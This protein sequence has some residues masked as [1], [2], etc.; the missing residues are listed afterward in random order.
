MTEYTISFFGM[1]HTLLLLSST[2]NP[3]LIDRERGLA[4]IPDSRAAEDTVAVSVGRGK[5]TVW[6]GKILL[7]YFFREVMGYPKSELAVRMD[8]AVFNVEIFDTP[9]HIARYNMT[10]C[11]LLSTFCY[12]APD[13]TE[14]TL[15]T[16]F[17][18]GIYRVILAEGDG[19]FRPE[20]LPGLR[21]I[22]GLPTASSALAVQNGAIILPPH[23]RLTP[24]HI[25]SAALSLTNGGQGS[26]RL[27]FG[28]TVFTVEI[29]TD[30]ATLFTP[31]SLI[32]SY[33]M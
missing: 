33:K 3:T 9:H 23:E 24:S 12:T 5:Y 22:N 20:I 6:E 17:C 28:D 16:V 25:I 14:H 30:G 2:D 7:S 29:D 27:S 31:V 13:L 19:T 15:Y 1:R 11:K 4:I 21:V 10:K 18:D 8:D 32:N 26:V